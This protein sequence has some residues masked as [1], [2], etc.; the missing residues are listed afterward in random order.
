MYHFLLNPRAFRAILAGTKK[1][2]VR[3]STE[4]EPFD[5]AS[6]VSGDIL[7]FENTDTGEKLT[8]ALVSAVHYKDAEALLEHEDIHTTLSSTSDPVLGAERLRS[9]PG[10]REGMIKNGVWAL[11]LTDPRQML[12]KKNESKGEE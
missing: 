2:E 8:A 11:H 4:Q 10:Y 9:F 12:C 5:Y 6:L 7:C 1:T 3:V